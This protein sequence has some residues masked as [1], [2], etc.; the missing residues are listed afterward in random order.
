MNKE[1]LMGNKGFDPAFP[2]HQHGKDEVA[3]QAN[4]DEAAGGGAKRDQGI[5]PEASQPQ[6]PRR[7]DS[8]DHGPHESHTGNPA[9]TRAHNIRGR[10]GSESGGGKN[11]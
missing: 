5:A 1:I 3:A 9:S 6:G 11:K 4:M 10:S 7:S 2:Q 8:P